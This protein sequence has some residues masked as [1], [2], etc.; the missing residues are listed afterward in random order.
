MTAEQIIEE[1]KKMEPEEISK[2]RPYFWERPPE[3]NGPAPLSRCLDAV[4]A[5]EGRA[6]VEAVLAARPFPHYEG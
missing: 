5:P 3:Q 2:L 1:I 6:R 4:N